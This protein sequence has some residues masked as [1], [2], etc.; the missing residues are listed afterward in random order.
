MNI[1]LHVH[2][3]LPNDYSLTIPL[4]LR[5]LPPL[6]SL[7]QPFDKILVAN[8]GEIACR[9]SGCGQGAGFG[10]QNTL[11]FRFP[12]SSG[13]LE[14]LEWL[15][16]LYTVHAC[17]NMNNACCLGSSADRVRS[18]LGSNPTRG[19]SF[20]SGKVTALRV[21]CCYV[22]VCGVQ[23]MRTC[24]EM[25]IKSVA[26]YSDADT[27]AVGTPSLRS[28]VYYTL[29]TCTCTCTFASYA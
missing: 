8:R 6:C 27:Q 23:V 15:C 16:I 28:C 25:G 7:M 17:M 9:V 24:K 1:T 2:V 21:L 3:Y 29:Y 22:V 14:K 12:K 5:L 26:I 10:S 4:A 13:S 11:N 20:F 19:S 18:V